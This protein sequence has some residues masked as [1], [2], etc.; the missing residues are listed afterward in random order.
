MDFRD[1]LPNHHHQQ[2]WQPQR[3]TLRLMLA[4][5]L[6]E[7]NSLYIYTYNILQRFGETIK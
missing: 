4:A 1:P 7:P 2:L 5:K 6:L 3:D